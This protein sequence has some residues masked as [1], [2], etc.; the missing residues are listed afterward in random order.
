MQRIIPNWGGKLDFSRTRRSV[1]LRL[2]YKLFV[3]PIEA[4]HGLSYHYISVI[5]DWYYGVDTVHKGSRPLLE[6][7]QRNHYDPTE[8]KFLRWIFRNL[9]IDCQQYSFVDFGSGKGRVLVAAAVHHFI[10]VIGVEYSMDLHEEALRNIQSA[11]RL[12]CRKVRSVWMDA[13]EFDIPKTPCILYFYNPFGMQ[14][15]E[16]VLSNV[17]AS[18]KYLPRPLFIVYVNPVLHDLMIRQ[19]EMRLFKSMKWCNLYTW[20]TL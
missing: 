16:R 15:M 11:R 12:R 3:H 13:T 5:C 1:P 17:Q 4:L 10:Q 2:R 6:D 7:S 9:P 18:L 20:L 14:I 19:P 8:P